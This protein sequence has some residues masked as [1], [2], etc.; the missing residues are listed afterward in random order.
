MEVSQ[1]SIMLQ[2]PFRHISESCR[3]SEDLFEISISLG[4]LLIYAFY[5]YA[6]IFIISFRILTIEKFIC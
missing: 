5:G 1:I 2:N 4:K 3:I 6:E